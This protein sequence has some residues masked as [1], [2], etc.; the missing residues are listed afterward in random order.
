MIIFLNGCSSSGKS[1]IAKCL[2]DLLPAPYVYFNPDTFLAALCP[3]QRIDPAMR[4]DGTD[5]LYYNALSI[6]GG[7]AGG[8]AKIGDGTNAMIV[9]TLAL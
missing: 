1:S 3:D 5:G 7:R 6:D 8:L 2:L 4:K 9:R